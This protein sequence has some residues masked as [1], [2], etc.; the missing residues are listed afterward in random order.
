MKDIS[1]SDRIGQL[2]MTKAVSGCLA[3][4]GVFHG[5]ATREEFWWW[6]LAYLALKF[7][8]GTTETIMEATIPREWAYIAAMPVLAAGLVLSLGTVVP[9]LAVTSRH[10]HDIGKSG[11]WQTAWLA[12]MATI[13]IY[14]IATFVAI[15]TVQEAPESILVP[16]GILS[17]ALLTVAGNAAWWTAWM[18]RQG[19]R[20]E[21]RYRPDPREP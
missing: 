6:I 3:R 10:L 16:L 12:L 8:M 15:Y 18:V 13:P 19:Q 5:R 2:P 11:W 1:S 20:G 9:T 21:N 7:G 14:L 17:M 4:Y